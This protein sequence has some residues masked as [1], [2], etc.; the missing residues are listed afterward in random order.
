MAAQTAVEELVSLCASVGMPL[1]HALAE[2]S[3]AALLFHESDP[4]AALVPLRRAWAR[5][6]SRDAPF[7]AACLGHVPR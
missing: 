7:E 2:Q 5:W 3:Q 6:L 4:A 1:L